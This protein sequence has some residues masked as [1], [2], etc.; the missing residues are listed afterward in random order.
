MAKSSMNLD[1]TATDKASRVIRGVGKTGDSVGRGFGKMGALAAGAMGGIAVAAASA[2]AAMAVDF[3]QRSI[4][5]FTEAQASQ[6]KFDDAFSRSPGLTAAKG[7]ID[8]L[9]QSLALKTKFDDDATK[10]AAALLSKF[11]LTGGQIEKLLPLVQDYAS[12]TGKDLGTSSQLLG[13]ALAGNAKALKA[14]GI[15]FKPTGDR[16]KDLAALMGLLNDKV[17]GFAEKE[18]KTA[19]GTADILS[20]Q[21]G[22]VQE[23]IGSYLVPALT[24]IGQWI[25]S[26]VIPAVQS[27]VAWFQQNLSPVISAV[28]GWVMGTLVPALQNLASQFMTNVWPA[29]QQV[30]GIIAEN[31]QPVIEALQQFWANTLQPAIAKIIPILGTVAKV[32]GI[33]VGALAVVISW[34]VGKVAPVFYKI[35]GPAIGFVIEVV[36]KVAGAI[37]WVIENFGSLVTF[38]KGIPQKFR[39]GL[40]TLAS[41]VTAPFRLAF[42]G[43]ASLWNNTVGRLSFTAPDWIPGLG[44]KGWDV[45]DIPMLAKG[46]TA[47]A[48]GLALVGEN[49]PELLAMNRGASVVPLD[50]A[51]GGVHLHIGTL[52]AGPGWERQ[53]AAAVDKAMGPT[54]GYRPA[55]VAVRGR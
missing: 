53:L 10:S 49:G 52:V 39:D 3:G 41:I 1:I 37:E 48:P 12:F 33:V 14:L 27:L 44:G 30:A 42:N 34:I 26:S 2:G 43:I 38:V 25:I 36:G 20:N 6:A 32:I 15:D 29:I 7:K 54:G 55:N 8:A 35:L 13:K 40:S 5:A 18:G 17:G 23:T 4:T 50:R 24:S 22:E 19:A 21:F 28:A 45:P 11:D 9:A 47:I 46:G 16:A 31:L 51:G